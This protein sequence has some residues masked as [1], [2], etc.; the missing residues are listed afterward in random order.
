MNQMK[1]PFRIPTFA[2]LFIC[3]A[4]PAALAGERGNVPVFERSVSEMRLVT[5]QP[6]ARQPA[7]IELDLS[8]I[9]F[10]PAGASEL[11]GAVA[12]QTGLVGDSSRIIS[13]HAS[14]G[15]KPKGGGGLAE[16]ATNPGA[17]L[18]QMQIQNVFVPNSHNSSGYANTF[19]IQPV[20]PF[21]LGKDSYFQNLIT[22]T[23]IPVVTTPNPDEPPGALI[24]IDGTTDLGDTT[25]LALLAH[26]QKV[27]D[28]FGYL[29]G[30]IGT[31]QIPTAT[32]DRTGTEKFSIGP[33]MVFV[34][35][36]HDLFTKG[37][38]L[39]FGGYGYNLWSV[40]G[41]ESRTN[42]NKL[43]AG[44]VLTYHFADF[45]GQKGWYL[46]WTDELMSFD[47]NS[48]ENKNTVSTPLG[49]ALGKVFNIGK[50]PVN[51]Y[52]GGDYYVAHRGTDP[53]YDIKLN[54]TFL[55]P[56]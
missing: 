28:D 48:A 45:L 19:I 27:S 38:T 40:F 41:E 3:M 55:F 32:D 44:P 35:S 22:R 8:G 56:E 52:L 33:G 26:Q 39:Q 5:Q 18:V 53:V 16:Q 2:I 29:W 20:I 54:V 46:R 50:Q 30:P 4:A 36:K 10:V 42:V 12:V 43:F 25:V 24:T 14:A 7:G 11:A 31:V 47:W 1:Q 23:T 9:E 17:A 51:V 37:D 13:H 15:S 34:G 49:A 6:V 21:S